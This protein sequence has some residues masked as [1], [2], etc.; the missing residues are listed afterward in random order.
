MQRKEISHE[1]I[2]GYPLAALAPV[3]TASAYI[4]ELIQQSPPIPWAKKFLF[5]MWGRYGGVNH[6]LNKL[7][8]EK[9]SEPYLRKVDYRRC[10]L[11]PMSVCASMVFDDDASKTDQ[12]TRAASLVHSALRFQ[13]DLLS[14]RLEPDKFRHDPGEMGQ[15]PNLFST[16]M[17]SSGAATRIHK[18]TKNNHIV[19]LC[20]SR[21]YKVKVRDGGN[22]VTAE[23]IRHCFNSVLKIAEQSESGSRASLISNADMR[24]RAEVEALVQS[25]P[26]NRTSMELLNNA[27]FIVCLDHQSPRDDVEAS[28]LTHG[29]N[30][31]NRWFHAS[32]QL[33]IFTN[34]RAGCVINFRC[35]VDGNVQTRTMSEVVGRAKHMTFAADV[36]DAKIPMEPLKWNLEK[37]SD[38]LLDR[39]EKVVQD[40]LCMHNPLHRIEGIGREVFK[41]CGVRPDAAFTFALTCAGKR[42]WGKTPNV[43]QAV[44]MSR[45]RGVPVTFPMI[46]TQR[47][48]ETVD[49]LA[50]QPLK[51][52]IDAR[53]LI[54]LLEDQVEYVRNWRRKLPYTTWLPWMFKTT[55]PFKRFLMFNVLRQVNPYLAPDTHLAISHP[56]A[57]TGVNYLGRPGVCSDVVEFSTIHYY[58][59]DRRIDMVFAPSTRSRD[60]LPE[61]V[62]EVERCVREVLAVLSENRRAAPEST[63][64]EEVVE[65]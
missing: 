18:S 57:R 51:G 35:Y 34:G 24:Y 3:D 64:Q 54:Q 19:V 12:A 65:V 25:D 17:V 7:R 50:T 41:T 10:S 36:P 20:R 45:Y 53:Q 63:R 43:Q 14:G 6:F 5:R 9:L 62:A 29:K 22:T 11:P 33:V 58:L 61:F 40:N 28:V 16:C 27:I 1:R 55:T 59:F 30:Y 26:D 23:Q 47:V 37:D 8:D 38:D 56:A 32:Q 48:Y 4:E 15:Y 13:D 49:A 42:V 60:Q 46:T 39:V 2:S 31:L 52:N 21:Q 44:S